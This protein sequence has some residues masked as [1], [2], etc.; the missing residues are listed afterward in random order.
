MYF[1]GM[2]AAHA[3][4]KYQSNDSTYTLSWQADTSP[5]FNIIY[6]IH[7]TYTTKIDPA[8]RQ[9]LHYHKVIKQRN[10]K[11]NWKINYNWSILKARSDHGFQWPITPETHNFMS[12]LFHLRTRSLQINDS[13]FYT[14]DVEDQLWRLCGA[15]SETQDAK[16]FYASFK[17]VTFQFDSVGTVQE[18]KWDTDLL[19]NRLSSAETELVIV[20]GPEPYNVPY[21]ISFIGKKGKKVEMK[22]EDYTNKSLQK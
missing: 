12:M 2:P 19:T 14:L 3:E 8:S 1:Q 20:L 7:N 4:M 13:L 9:P 11:Q 17:S 21:F 22:L 18:R 6:P 16:N 15:V 10:V 5:V